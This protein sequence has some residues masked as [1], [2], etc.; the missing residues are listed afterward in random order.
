MVPVGSEVFLDGE[1]VAR[2]GVE[3]LIAA[4]S[5][6]GMGSVCLSGGS[7][8]KRMYSLLASE[9]FAGR[10]AWDRIHWW[11]GDERF[12]APSDK[13]SNEA[14]VRGAMFDHVTVDSGLVHP[15]WTVGVGLEESAAAYGRALRVFA[16]GP[17][18][19]RPLFDLV[20]L[21]IGDDGHTASLFPGKPAVEEGHHWVM[22]V[23]EA[24]LSPFI[25]RLTLTLPALANSA[26][27]V[28]LA[29]GEG[30]RAMLGRVAAGERLPAGRVTCA[31][32]V[33]WLVDRAA[34]GEV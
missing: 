31:G 14:M 26:G 16:A 7:T 18:A 5:G 17:R 30:K 9:E 34:A 27:V 21:G 13:S 23:P 12:V 1:A 15:F 24:G 25:P 11:W 20:L 2:A 6:E 29:V 22:P 19:G 8:P 32:G 10:V 28:F 33:S 4:T 3:R